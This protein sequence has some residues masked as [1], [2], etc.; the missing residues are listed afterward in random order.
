MARVVG[1]DPSE[2]E[3]DRLEAAAR[4]MFHTVGCRVLAQ[5]TDSSVPQITYAREGGVS[6]GWLTD[7]LLLVGDSVLTS[8]VFEWASVVERFLRLTEQDEDFVSNQHLWLGMDDG[9]VRI[10]TLSPRISSRRCLVAALA[11]ASAE[12]SSGAGRCVSSDS[13]TRH[14]LIRDGFW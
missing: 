9:A 12:Q 14:L 10:G 1:G 5:H 4:Y 7:Q 13:S 8:V 11:R 2:E 3:N 6:V